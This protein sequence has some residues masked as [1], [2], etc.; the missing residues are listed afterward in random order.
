MSPFYQSKTFVSNIAYHINIRVFEIRICKIGGMVFVEKLSGGVRSI[1]FISGGRDE[2]SVCAW[3][4]WKS[5]RDA[6]VAGCFVAAKACGCVPVWGRWFVR[7]VG[8]RG[9]KVISIYSPLWVRR[10]RS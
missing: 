4:C 3:G 6:L 5:E 10:Q 2:L 9:V 1:S 7:G 8:G